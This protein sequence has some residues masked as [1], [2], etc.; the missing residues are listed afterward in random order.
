MYAG[1][2][3]VYI[4]QLNGMSDSVLWAG[5]RQAVPAVTWNLIADAL[6]EQNELESELRTH[7]AS[8]IYD[9]DYAF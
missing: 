6:A 3:S 1:N 4:Q 5:V 2:V 7:V 8:R 9:R